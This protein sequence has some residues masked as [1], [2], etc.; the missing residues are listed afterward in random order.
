MNFSIIRDVRKQQPLIHHLTN[1]VVMNFTANGLL[2]FGGTPIMAKAKEE[3]EAIVTIADGVLIN[4]G[5]LT[6]DEVPAMI[7]TG[8][9]ANEKNIPVVLDPVGVSATP[10]RTAM[11][12]EILNQVQ[13]TAIKGNAS[14]LAHLVGRSWESK[15]V[16]SIGGGDVEEVA[17]QVAKTYQTT[18]VLTGKTDIICTESK[19][20]HNQSGHEILTRV[21]GGGCLLGSVLTACLTTNYPAWQQALTAVSFYGLAA[22]Y[23]ASNP[24]VKG[25]GTFIPRFIDALSLN[26]A[27]LEGVNS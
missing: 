10:F 18:A 17:L 22:E 19:L 13:P 15:G 6:A 20:A 1:Q 3:V 26:M 16:D 5:T 2:S 21:T 4:I 24:E 8:K 9:T 23:T 12:K 7:L 25:S 11:V 14:E 27:D